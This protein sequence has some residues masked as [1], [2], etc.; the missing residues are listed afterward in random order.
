MTD[1]RDYHITRFLNLEFPHD[2]MEELTD[3]GHPAIDFTHGN[4]AYTPQT[5]KDYLDLHVIGQD[6]AKKLLAIS[7]FN[8]AMRLF[9]K[10]AGNDVNIEK[11]NVLLLGPTGVGKTYLV[12]T[13]AKYLN[14]PVVIDD[15]TNFTSGGYVGRD[16]GELLENLIKKADDMLAVGDESISSRS[17][18][19][20]AMAQTGIVYLDEVD[21]LS[22]RYSTGARGDIAT[23]AIQQELL[24]LIDSGPYHLTTNKKI[25]SGIAD[26][27]EIDT[28]NI[29]FI[30]GGSFM[31]IK[32]IVEKRMSDCGIGFGSKVRSKDEYDDYAKHVITEDLIKFGMIPELIGRI[33]AKV[34]L[35][36]LVRKDLIKILTEPKDSI[37]A[38]YKRLFALYGREIIFADSALNKIAEL[39][40]ENKTGARGLRTI[41]EHSLR[42]LMFE[43]PSN[44]FG[45][46]IKI[47]GRN[48][49]S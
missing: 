1:D 3:F 37:I 13:L 31:D 32:D 12:S 25:P 11:S 15:A 22:T 10:E 19:V 42:D 16:V 35:N 7:V 49:T 2:E 39:A 4:F 6:D 20:K 23:I 46:V 43:A 21:K 29:L 47:T 40:L 41:L 44:P 48:I 9:N 30:F 17:G 24:R 34:H 45:P 14:V 5:I 33:P 26:M 38:Q 8:R 36:P 18:R 28:T 27:G